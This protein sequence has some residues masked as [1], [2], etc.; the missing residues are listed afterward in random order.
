MI[1]IKYKVVFQIIQKIN[2]YLIIFN[3]I[4]KYIKKIKKTLFCK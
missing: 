3:N 2:L 4:Y 1:F